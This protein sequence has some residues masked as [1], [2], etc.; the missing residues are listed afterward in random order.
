MNLHCNQAI[1]DP[2]AATPDLPE[3]LRRFIIECCDIDPAQ[4]FASAAEA[5]AAIEV[6]SPNR[7]CTAWIKGGTCARVVG[8]SERELALYQAI[9]NQWGQWRP[10]PKTPRG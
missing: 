4:R 3:V 7:S 8:V 1:P 5:L 9:L 10:R 2:A 6:V